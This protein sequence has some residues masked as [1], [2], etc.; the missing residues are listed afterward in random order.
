MSGPTMT[1]TAK[2]IAS[3]SRARPRRTISMSTTINVMTP[4][5][6][7]NGSGVHRGPPPPPRHIRQHQKERR[8]RISPRLGRIND[9]RKRQRSEHL[10]RP[11]ADQNNRPDAAHERQKPVPLP[12]LHRTNG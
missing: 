1:A 2:N 4:M 11:I 6:S 9:Q 5:N 7:A 3:G 10:I 12:M 8:R